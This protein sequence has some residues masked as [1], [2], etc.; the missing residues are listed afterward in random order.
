[1]PMYD[2]VAPS[3]KMVSHGATVQPLSTTFMLKVP[4]P[5][6]G[7]PARTTRSL[8]RYLTRA[9]SHCSLVTPLGSSRTSPGIVATWNGGSGLPPLTMR[10]IGNGGVKALVLEEKLRISV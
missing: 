4:R 10:T 5:E 3:M 7:E 2:S 8:F 6:L 9:P 1:T